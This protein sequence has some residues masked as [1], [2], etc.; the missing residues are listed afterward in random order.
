MMTSDWSERL[1][2]QREAIAAVGQTGVL[3]TC[4]EEVGVELDW[5][6]KKHKTYEETVILPSGWLA[7]EKETRDQLTMLGHCCSFHHKL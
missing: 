4:I 3:R 2:G 5:K 7:V 6:R 1:E